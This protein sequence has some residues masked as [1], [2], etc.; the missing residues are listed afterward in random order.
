MVGIDP[1]P[2]EL[3]SAISGIRTQEA[4]AADLKSAPFDHSGKMATT[5]YLTCGK[6]GKKWLV[7]YT[8]HT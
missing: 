3:K 5:T 2:L 4:N 8:L 1:N 7:T 6:E